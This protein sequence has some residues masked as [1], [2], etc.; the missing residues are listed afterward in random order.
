MKIGI[1]KADLPQV[2]F[3][4][5]LGRET[6]EINYDLADDLCVSNFDL[7]VGLLW[8]RGDKKPRTNP[9]LPSAAGAGAE[10]D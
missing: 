3:F 7:S 1:K 8:L 6:D 5:T 9:R 10:G 4:F 2:C